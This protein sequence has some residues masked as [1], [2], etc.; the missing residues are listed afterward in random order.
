MVEVEKRRADRLRVMTWIFDA[1]GG[2]ETVPVSG[3]ELL[4]AIGLDDHELGDVCTFLSG[5]GLIKKGGGGVWGHYTPFMITITHKGIREMEQSFK[6]PTEPTQHFPPAISVIHIEGN[7]IGSALQSGSSGAHQRKHDLW[8]G[9]TSRGTAKALPS[10]LEKA[11]PLRLILVATVSGVGAAITALLGISRL[12]WW[13]LALI[14][15][16]VGAVLAAATYAITEEGHRIL[17]LWNSTGHC[18]ALLI[19]IGVY[20]FIGT[21]P[22]RTAN[23]VANGGGLPPIRARLG[24]ASGE[25]SLSTT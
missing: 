19:G 12:D 8:N 1:S 11:H 2:S 14:V 3:P 15:F 5:E 24:V 16:A 4:E 9:D 21:S 13:S 17:A 10:E 7:V 25:R 20:D 22:A 18:I 6:A 23:V